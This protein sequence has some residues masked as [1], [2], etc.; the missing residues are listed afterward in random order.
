[1][2]QNNAQRFSG[3]SRLE[4]KRGLRPSLFTGGHIMSS[5]ISIE[6]FDGILETLQ[7][8][9]VDE[10]YQGNATLLWSVKHSLRD[11]KKLLDFEDTIGHDDI[12]PIHYINL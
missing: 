5:T 9:S 7:G 10:V 2:V 4:G 8:K 1:M 3:Y 6:S 12:V 11:N